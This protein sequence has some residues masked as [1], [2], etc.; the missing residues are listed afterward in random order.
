MNSE[1]RRGLRTLWRDERSPILIA[2]ASGW[3]LSIGVR[4][5]YP[6]LLPHLR[7]AYGFDLTTA[8]LLLTVLWVAYAL[9]QLPGGILADRI[10]EGRILVVST[11]LST[12]TIALVATATSASLLFAATALFG[13]GTALYGVAR[14]TALSDVFPD[15]DGAAIGVTLAAGEVGNAVLPPVAGLIAGAIAWQYG[16]GFAV[17]L[18]LVASGFLWVTVPARTSGPTSAVDSLSLETGRYVLGEISRPPIVLATLIQLLGFSVWQAF[19]GFYPT[20]LI[21]MKGFSPAFATVLFGAFFALGVLVQPLSGAA[22]DRFGIRRSVPVVMGVVAVGLG[23]LPLLE[24]PVSIVGVTILASGLLGVT[25]MTMPYLT[26]SLPTDI[27]G[28][29]LGVVRT[30]F[31]VLGAGSPA[32]AGALADR[33]FFD[34]VFFLFA[35]L[36]GV[37]I[38]LSRF[39][40]EQ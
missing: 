33:G 4:L 26:A 17:P 12:V 21:E 9:G 2:I 35:V 5:V 32:V 36:A 3:F 10:G 40:P 38:L 28:T 23:L 19:T 7:A 34:E 8:G 13:F 24:G 14:Y 1:I 39:L 27:Q 6:V 22:Y 16:F 29:G 30:G 18:F 20:Y 15:N 31:M 11:A 37:A 25:A